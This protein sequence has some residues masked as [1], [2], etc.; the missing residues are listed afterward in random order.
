MHKLGGILGLITLSA[1]PALATEETKHRMSDDEVIWLAFTPF[2]VLLFCLLTLWGLSIRGRVYR[3][4]LVKRLKRNYVS[5]CSKEKDK[6][7]QL[8]EEIATTLDPNRP[9]LAKFSEAWDKWREEDSKVMGRKW[10]W[11]L[12]NGY[13]RYSVVERSMRLAE[14][15]TR[16]VK[17]CQKMLEEARLGA[18]DKKRNAAMIWGMFWSEEIIKE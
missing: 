8:E 12:K 18:E 4:S 9:G 10:I 11:N 17:R 3:C 2:W 14:D 5:L 13:S 6:L 1:L 15:A 7:K 16:E